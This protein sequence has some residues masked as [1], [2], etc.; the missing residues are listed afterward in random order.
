[1]IEKGGGNYGKVRI[2]INDAERA[3]KIKRDDVRDEVTYQRNISLASADQMIP[4]ELQRTG[5]HV[6]VDES[7]EHGLSNR[8]AE[9]NA[10]N[11]NRSDRCLLLI[12]QEVPQTDTVE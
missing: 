8:P 3:G 11:L 2:E 7:C 6:E 12:C 10:E 4:S 5:V 9:C 1:M